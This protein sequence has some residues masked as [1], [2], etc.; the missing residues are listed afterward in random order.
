MYRVGATF[1]LK[2]GCYPEYKKAHDELWPEIAQP[3][4]DEGVSMIIYHYQD[5]LFM[6]AEAPSKEHWERSQSGPATD[7]WHVYMSSL[8]LTDEAGDALVEDLHEAFV[9]GRFKEMES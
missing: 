3:M 4:A 5:R 7:R 9:F 6:H 2:P 8:M 1:A